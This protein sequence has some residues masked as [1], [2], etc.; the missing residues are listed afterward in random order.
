MF[1]GGLILSITLMAFSVWLFRSERLGWPNDELDEP[2][3]QD[4]RSRRRRGR[5]VVNALFFLCGLLILLATWATP[6]N[7]TW[8]IT[9]WMSA[10][11]VL[12]TILVFA[13]FDVLRTL[14]HHR[15]RIHRLSKK[16]RGSDSQ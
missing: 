2:I 8:W 3:D 11:L 14:L 10:T 16:R 6:D 9:G 4:Y 12:L 15:R 5:R 13:G 7:R 1:A